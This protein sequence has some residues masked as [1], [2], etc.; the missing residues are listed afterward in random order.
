MLIDM[1]QLLCRI[2]PVGRAYPLGVESYS[3]PRAER[4]FEHVPNVR[5]AGVCSVDVP[6]W[7]GV[8]RCRVETKSR[9][10]R[11]LSCLDTFLFVVFFIARKQTHKQIG[12]LLSIAEVE[13]SF[14]D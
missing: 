4:E 11:A 3:R 13:E 12:R 7:S 6:C 14:V 9:K 1:L 10:V 2:T 5:E 8:R